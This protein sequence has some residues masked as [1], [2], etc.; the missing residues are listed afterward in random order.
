M[1]PPRLQPVDTGPESSVGLEGLS[2]GSE[3]SALWAPALLGCPRRCCCCCSRVCDLGPVSS[4]LCAPRVRLRSSRGPLP[5]RVCTPALRPPV[6]CCFPSISPLE[7]ALRVANPPFPGE[8]ESGKQVAGAREAGGARDAGRGAGCRL[9]DAGTSARPRAGLRP[10]AWGRRMRA[11]ARLLH[12]AKPGAPS[13][14]SPPLQ[15]RA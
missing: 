15:T 4:P 9:E 11:R 10:G 13:P 1:V 5:A 14:R 8:V 2:L 3:S 7:H 12:P 6:S